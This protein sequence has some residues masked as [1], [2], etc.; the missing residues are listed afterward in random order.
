MMHSM[1]LK[2][3]CPINKQWFAQNCGPIFILDPKQ[4]EFISFADT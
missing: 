4:N 1:V 2:A 3:L